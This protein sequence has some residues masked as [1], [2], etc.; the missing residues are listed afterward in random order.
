MTINSWC[1]EIE[2]AFSI[3]SKK[4]GEKEKSLLLIDAVEG[5]SELQRAGIIPSPIEFGLEK[6]YNDVCETLTRHF[7][8]MTT[9]GEVFG[10][11]TR[12]KEQFGKTIED[13]YSVGSGPFLNFA[14]TYWTFKIEVGDLFPE[15]HKKL[16]SQILLR[17]EFD[18]ARFFFPT[19][20]SAM[21]PPQ[22]RVE[23]QK[24]LLKEYA[25]EI[26]VELFVKQ[27]S[28]L[29]KEFIEYSYTPE[30]RMKRMNKFRKKAWNDFKEINDKH[31]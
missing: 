26:D 23:T 17:V 11:I 2:R 15:N 22:L 1:K 9:K 16:V 13:N 4:L 29:T 18:I 19:P 30:E 7:Y 5:T 24:K 31:T 20:G 3:L 6:F 27:N 12:I 8:K 25:P 10:D 21:I 14:K 28:I